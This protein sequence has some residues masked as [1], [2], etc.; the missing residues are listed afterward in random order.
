MAATASPP[1]LSADQIHWIADEVWA[2][3]Q[4]KGVATNFLVFGLGL[5]SI[6]WNKVNCL[7]RTVFIENYPSWI[8]KILSIEPGLE[9]VQVDYNSTVADANKWFQGSAG[10]WSLDLPSSVDRLCWDVILVDAPQGYKRDM[11]GRMQSAQLALEKAQR[12]VSEGRRQKVTVFMHD[13]ER[14]LEQRIANE[15]Y[16]KERQMYFLGTMDGP[17]GQ[18]SAWEYSKNVRQPARDASLGT[19]VP[20]G[21]PIE[22]GPSRPAARTVA[23]SLPSGPLVANLQGLV[24]EPARA[25]RPPGLWDLILAGGEGPGYLYFYPTDPAKRQL[26]RDALN[27]LLSQGAVL[28]EGDCRRPLLAYTRSLAR[29][30]GPAM[31]SDMYAEADRAAGFVSQS[32]TEPQEFIAA[33]YSRLAQLHLD[34]LACAAAHVGPCGST[35][36]ATAI[37]YHIAYH[38]ERLADLAADAKWLKVQ[39]PECSRHST[40]MLLLAVVGPWLQAASAALAGDELQEAL[41]DKAALW[42]RYLIWTSADVVALSHSIATVAVVPLTTY[43]EAQRH[44]ARQGA[45]CD[46]VLPAQ[47]WVHN[48]AFAMTFQALMHLPL[49]KA[50]QPAPASEESGSSGMAGLTDRLSGLA[51][52]F[53]GRYGGSLDDLTSWLWGLEEDLKG[54]QGGALEPVDMYLELRSQEHWS[55]LV[56]GLLNRVRREVEG[57][58]AAHA[59]VLVQKAAALLREPVLVTLTVRPPFWEEL[60]GAAVLDAAVRS[61]AAEVV[62]QLAQTLAGG[63]YGQAEPWGLKL[64]QCYLGAGRLE[65]A[66]KLVELDAAGSLRQETQLCWSSLAVWEM[67]GDACALG[68]MPGQDPALLARL[69]ETLQGLPAAR[70]TTPDRYMLLAVHRA[71]EQVQLAQ[72]GASLLPALHTHLA[73]SMWPEECVLIPFEALL[74]AGMTE[75]ALRPL[76]KLAA[77]ELWPAGARKQRGLDGQKALAARLGL[78]LLES[79][80]GGV[81]AVLGSLDA[82]T[83]GPV[84]CFL[85]RLLLERGE[86]ATAWQLLHRSLAA[87]CSWDTSVALEVVE[88]LFRGKRFEEVGDAW[89]VIAKS[90]LAFKR[91]RQRLQRLAA[92]SEAKRGSFIEALRLTAGL[93]EEYEVE[94]VEEVLYK[95]RELDIQVAERCMQL[96]SARHQSDLVA[97]TYRRLDGAQLASLPLKSHVAALRAYLAQIQEGSGRGSTG[98][99]SSNSSSSS[100]NDSTSAVTSALEIVQREAVALC[101]LSDA[102]LARTLCNAACHA[103]RHTDIQPSR[104]ALVRLWLGASKAAASKASRDSLLSAAQLALWGLKLLQETGADRAEL[105]AQLSAAVRAYTGPRTSGHLR[106]MLALLPAWVPGLQ[107]SPADWGALLCFARADAGSSSAVGEELDLSI[108]KELRGICQHLRESL[109]H[110]WVQKLAYREAQMA[111]LLVGDTL[112]DQ[113]LMTEAFEVVSKSRA[114]AK[115]VEVWQCQLAAVGERPMPLTA[116]TAEALAAVR[117]VGLHELKQGWNALRDMADNWQQP[118][119]SRTLLLV[120]QGLTSLLSE[121]TEAYAS[122]DTT[123]GAYSLLEPLAEASSRV[124]ADLLADTAGTPSSAGSQPATPP[125]HVLASSAAAPGRWPPL[126]IEMVIA[127]LGLLMACHRATESCP[128]AALG[129]SQLPAGVQALMHSLCASQQ[130][131]THAVGCR[132][133]EALW[134][135]NALQDWA[136]SSFQLE[137]HSEEGLVA[138]LE[139]YAYQEV[140]SMPIVVQP[141]LGGPQLE[142]LES[143]TASG[144]QAEQA[145]LGAVAGP[146]YTEAAKL[147]EERLS[148]VRNATTMEDIK[149]H[150]L[151]YGWMSQGGKGRSV[152]RLPE[153]GLPPS[154]PKQNVTLDLRASGQRAVDKARS[155]LE[156][157]YLHLEQ[158]HRRVHA[159]QQAR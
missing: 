44:L 145:A 141:R 46:V 92:L 76:G 68:V 122:E 43:V 85:T 61:N 130:P 116:R 47:T 86:P 156:R 2:A 21:F 37:A 33:V 65:A 31:G 126:D 119:S 100:S 71:S 32:Y 104:S 140:I 79:K 26:G 113:D 83:A 159:E 82:S 139:E 123:S 108:A 115:L 158:E 55:G 42:A 93:S 88:T 58:R 52:R 107:P 146:A 96:C 25:W 3:G 77:G 105:Q 147:R 118:P 12:C 106:S 91:E 54:A 114:A 66:I 155:A 34:W 10:R 94:V 5:D 45:G 59:E 131:V 40:E 97:T 70:C 129:Q 19:R 38:A 62:G 87:V 51:G 95:G 102:D 7:G 11:P 1:I 80:F 112:G 4:G 28:A 99:S 138:A 149:Q 57:G 22:E 64:L 132:L 150:L 39:Y 14:P 117:M 23:P 73:A 27:T 137:G 84:A 53:N 35:E 16:N 111:A 103:I 136:D 18:L 157:L 8:D 67:L 144:K 153:A 110:G 134:C 63:P 75:A 6:M 30:F 72:D 101:F 81:E 15:L 121:A 41:R 151:A 148:D 135:D 98:S 49:G 133:L 48:L 50:A 154:F 128:G 143:L 20:R 69:H 127:T 109:G 89:R 125:S 78:C 74:E 24:L 36:Q 120:L 124:A 17:G 90:G 13:M 9:V 29:S 142:R 152:F 56:R 60:G